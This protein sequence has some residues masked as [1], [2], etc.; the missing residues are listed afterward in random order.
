MSNQPETGARRP[1][2][3]PIETNWFDRLFI[4]VVIWVA[5]SLLWL[6]LIEPLW[7]SIWIATAISAVVGA[8]IIW[9]G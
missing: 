7:L 6:R 9:R 1:G 4:A 8:V 5:L 3:L 2:F